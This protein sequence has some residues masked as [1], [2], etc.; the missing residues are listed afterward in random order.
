MT[1]EPSDLHTPDQPGQPATLHLDGVDPIIGAV[2]SNGAGYDFHV[3]RL[4]LVNGTMPRNTYGSL[5]RD[6]QREDVE[7]ENI[8]V[9]R[10][11]PTEDEETAGAEVFLGTI[12]LHLAD[13]PKA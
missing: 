10:V 7:V 12:T 11:V 9:R 6:G 1:A 8:N 4:V 13:Q 5:E 3:E 2:M